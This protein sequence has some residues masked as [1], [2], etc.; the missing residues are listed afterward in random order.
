MT[1]DHPATIKGKGKGVVR[2]CPQRIPHSPGTLSPQEERQAL[3]PT[4][5]RACG[6]TQPKSYSDNF[7]HKRKGLP[8]YHLE[9]MQ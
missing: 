3:T 5:S 8:V 2:R 4:A 7:S 6:A 9:R 1:T